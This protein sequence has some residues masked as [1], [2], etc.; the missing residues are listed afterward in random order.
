MSSTQSPADEEESNT[1]PGGNSAV[2]CEVPA[3]VAPAA[4]TVASAP[5]TIPHASLTPVAPP[6]LY[7][8][9]P[10]TSFQLYSDGSY[11]WVWPGASMNPPQFGPRRPRG[12]R[13]ASLAILAL[14]RNDLKEV[15]RIFVVERT[16]VLRTSLSLG[17]VTANLAASCRAVETTIRP[18]STRFRDFGDLGTNVGGPPLD[19]AVGLVD[20]SVRDQ[21]RTFSVH[22]GCQCAFLEKSCPADGCDKECMGVARHPGC[23]FCYGGHEWG[24]SGRP[25]TGCQ[26]AHPPSKCY[27]PGC[28]GMCAGYALH[29]GAC[30]CTLGHPRSNVYEPVYHPVGV[31]RATGGGQPHVFQTNAGGARVRLVTSQ[32]SAVER[33]VQRSSARSMPKVPPWRQPLEGLELGERASSSHEE[34]VIDLI[35]SPTELIMICT[36]RDAPAAGVTTASNE[37]STSPSLSA[38]SETSD[39]A[40]AAHPIYQ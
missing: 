34:P 40:H 33:Q 24:G 27:V 10:G 12:T 36:P 19:P 35:Q 29:R 15:V 4:V 2:C 9:P 28:E 18:W 21:L 20:T 22:R 13:W 39:A 16:S 11:Y 38:S 7:D 8:P 25:T 17:M 14:C 26:C 30:V 31:V 5:A 32:P 1:G 23:C 3:A 37:T 6:V